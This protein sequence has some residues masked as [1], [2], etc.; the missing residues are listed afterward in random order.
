MDFVSACSLWVCAIERLTPSSDLW[1]FCKLLLGR[2]FIMFLAYFVFLTQ[3][4]FAETFFQTKTTTS[5]LLMV[6]VYMCVEYD[7]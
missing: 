4:V 1:Y 7:T 5:Y 6:C 2:G 3:Q